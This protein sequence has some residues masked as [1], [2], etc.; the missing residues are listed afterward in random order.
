[1]PI[2]WMLSIIFV[3]FMTTLSLSKSTQI[4]EEYCSQ[5]VI[6]LQPMKCS[7][8]P[9]KFSRPFVFLCAE[10][11]GAE[12]YE[13]LLF[14]TSAKPLM[15]L[16]LRFAVAAVATTCTNEQYHCAYPVAIDAGAVMWRTEMKLG[17]FGCV[18]SKKQ[19]FL[20]V[21]SARLLSIHTTSIAANEANRRCVS[22]VSTEQYF[23]STN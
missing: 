19:V 3:A 15:W 20:Y 5:S 9:K 18:Q 12:K 8:D 13:R 11:K 14:P 16:F 17:S 6:G 22:S 21:A 4:L 10:L 23:Y 1:M 2:E 7:F